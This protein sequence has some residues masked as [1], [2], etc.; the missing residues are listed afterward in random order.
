MYEDFE[1]FEEDEVKAQIIYAWTR[2]ICKRYETIA[3]IMW[4]FNDDGC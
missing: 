2:T 3:E 4:S 1:W